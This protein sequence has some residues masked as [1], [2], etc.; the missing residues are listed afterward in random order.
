MANGKAHMLVGGAVGLGLYFIHHRVIHD[1]ELT[2][3][4]VIGSFSFGAVGGLMADI[5]EPASNPR[6]RKFFH[7]ITFATIALLGK[8]HVCQLLKL[9][10]EDQRY[11]DWFLTCYGSHLYLDAQTPMGLPIL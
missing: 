6:H 3:E 9:A 11:L 8:D 2:L 4:G 10:V 1:Q 7:S 5:L